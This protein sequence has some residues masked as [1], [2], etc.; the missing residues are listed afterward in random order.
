[1]NSF[2]PSEVPMMAG[3]PV[4]RTALAMASKAASSEMLK[5]PIAAPFASGPYRTSR[6][7]LI[8]D[9]LRLIIGRGFGQPFFQFVFGQQSRTGANR[10]HHGHGVN[11]RPAQSFGH[12]QTFG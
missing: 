11:R 9:L 4:A 2:S 10:L 3:R 1:M 12:R 5:C 6:K 8:L 7:G